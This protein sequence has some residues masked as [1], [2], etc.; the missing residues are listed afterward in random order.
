MD[1]RLRSTI[2]HKAA[3]RIRPVMPMTL[4]FKRAKSFVVV[5]D[6][7]SGEKKFLGVPGPTPQNVPFWVADTP[8]FKQGIKDGSIVNLTP[9][10]QMPGYKAAPVVVEE[11]E[12]EEPTRELTEAEKLDAAEATEQAEVPQAPFGGQ[13][14]TPV[15]PA[16]KI[17]KVRASNAR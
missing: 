14:M 3:R 12:E 11:V 7:T 8:T 17:G 4:Y 6:N 16:P 5:S 10:D 9:P 2:F 15:P 1:Y 13:P